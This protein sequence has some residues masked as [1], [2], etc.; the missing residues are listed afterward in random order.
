MPGLPA[1][2]HGV[3]V[4]RQRGLD[5]GSHRAR[6]LDFEMLARADLA[7]A[8]TPAHQDEIRYLHPGV[9][10]VLITEFLPEDHPDHGR[11]VADPVGGTREEYEA[12]YR[13][14][15][16]AIRGLFDRVEDGWLESLSEEDVG[17]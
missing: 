3:E 14:L 12:T 5:L 16:A 17:E 13:V 1:A 7:V 11:G 8:M 15:E 2:S 10:S 9:R 6:L 4:A